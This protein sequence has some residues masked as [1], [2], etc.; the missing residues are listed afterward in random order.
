MAEYKK[1][2]NQVNYR[3]RKESIEHNDSRMSKANNESEVWNVVNEVIT[4]KNNI[5][6]NWLNL[7][8][9]T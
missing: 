1:L 7:L 8:M 3:I 2:R 6:L 9:D 4:P 5:P